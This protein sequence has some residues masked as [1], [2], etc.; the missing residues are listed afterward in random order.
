M[1]YDDFASRAARAAVAVGVQARRPEFAV[2]RAVRRRRSAGS[3]DPQNHSNRPPTCRRDSTKRSPFG[4][5]VVAEL[6]A[7]AGSDLGVRRPDRIPRAAGRSYDAGREKEASSVSGPRHRP[8]VP[9][10]MSLPIRRRVT[11]GFD[12]SDAKS[13]ESSQRP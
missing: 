10:P 2:V 3:A 8:S 12:T 9:S 6:R 1:N 5:S 4:A 11:T 7:V 13:G